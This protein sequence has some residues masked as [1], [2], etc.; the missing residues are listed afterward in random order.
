MLK[1]EYAGHS[2]QDV[3]LMQGACCAAVHMGHT[4]MSQASFLSNGAQAAYALQR[5]ECDT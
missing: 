1:A 5:A 3:G 4:Q 2:L